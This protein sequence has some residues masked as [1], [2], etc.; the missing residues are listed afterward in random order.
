MASSGRGG[1]VSEEPLNDLIRIEQA[2][3][4]LDHKGKNIIFKEPKKMIPV[5][6]PKFKFEIQNSNFVRKLS[7]RIQNKQRIF[8]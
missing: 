6:A 5:S 7:A 4:K 2:Q 3:N 1:R 8:L